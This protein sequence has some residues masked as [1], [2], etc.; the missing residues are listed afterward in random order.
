MI[1]KVKLTYKGLIPTTIIKKLKPK[2]KFLKN[3]ASQKTSYLKT[4][5]N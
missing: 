1:L 2:K 4:A 5:L 3:G